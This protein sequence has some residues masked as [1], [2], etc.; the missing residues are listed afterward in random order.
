[1]EAQKVISP[2]WEFALDYYASDGIAQ[3]LLALQDEDGYQVNVLIL[4]VWLTS[5]G[6]KLHKLPEKEEQAGCWF[7]DVSVNIRALRKSVKPEG[8]EDGDLE[9]LLANCYKKMLSAELAAEEIELMLLYQQHLQW[10]SPF[11]ANEGV[12]ARLTHNLSCCWHQMCASCMTSDDHAL[13]QL[14]LLELSHSYL[15]SKRSL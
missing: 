5:R 13:R 9:T 14:T 12:L 6:L 10:S 7:N 2:L 1:M 11:N 15:K 4:A 8:S 3:C